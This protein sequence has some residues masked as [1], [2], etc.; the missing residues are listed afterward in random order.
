MAEQNERWKAEQL[1]NGIRWTM[2]SVQRADVVLQPAMSSRPVS[3]ERAPNCLSERH[4]HSVRPARPSRIFGRRARIRREWSPPAGTQHGEVFKIKGKGLPDI[5]TYRSG[6]QIVQ[7][8]IE[9]PKKL[10]EQQKKLLR[11]FAETED[12]SASVMPI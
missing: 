11:D 7:I 2:P 1:P 4:H 10:T 8:L 3:C 9:I 5:R 6:D 12:N